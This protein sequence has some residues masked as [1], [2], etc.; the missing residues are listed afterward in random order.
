[1]TVEWEV[2][3]PR[4]MGLLAAGLAPPEAWSRAGVAPP[5][6]PGETAEDRAV[7]A[8]D[9]L[10]ARL[11]A[12]LGVMLAAVAEVAADRGEAAVAREAALAGPRLSARV[13]AWLPAAGLALGVGIEPGTLRV[14]GLT[15]AGWGLLAVGVLLTWA[16]RAW[17]RR[18]VDR[19]AHPRPVDADAVVMASALLAA[20]LETGVDVPR[21]MREVGDALVEPD[22]CAGA[23]SLLVKG[24]WEGA[25]E[26]WR[27][28]AS[29]VEAAWQAGA[30][31]GPALT[32]TRRAAARRSRAQAAV[33]AG[34]LGVRVALPLTLCLLPAFVAVG[35]APLLVA[36]VGGAAMW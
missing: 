1:M 12:P 10:A 6:P 27:E 30:R 29:A 7:V 2:A 28:V 26:R 17:T 13:L 14:L 31:A 19:A 16:G 18:I 23:D 36:M 4:V 24:R 33:A 22:L 25:P 35:I 21:A 20:V 15:A 32:A 11:G 9:A 5:A 3:L 8:A 34:E